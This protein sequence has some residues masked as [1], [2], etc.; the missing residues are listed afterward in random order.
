MKP[1]LLFTD[2][3][4][5]L[6]WR[7]SRDMA[8]L[9]DDL[10]LVKLFDAMAQGDKFLYD[11]SM[12]AVLQGLV[13]PE[14][15][16]YRQDV[17]RDC[18][19]N[20]ETVREMYATAVTALESQR[21]VWPFMREHPHSIVRQ[22]AHALRLYATALKSLRRLA[23]QHSADFCSAGMST[24]FRMLKTELDDAYLDELDEQLTRLEFKG[25]VLMSAELGK[26]NKGIRYVLR[27]PLARRRDLKQLIGLSPRASYSFEIG[28][29][30]DAGAR[31]LSELQDRAM[32]TVGNALAQSAD[33][34]RSFFTT[35]QAELGFYVCC[36][37]LHD[38]L[39]EKGEPV[40]FPVPRERELF[41]LSFSGLYDV[42]LALGSDVPVVGND[43]NAD[44]KRLVMITGA[45]S[46]GKSTFL[47]SVGLA[48]L[49]MQSGMFV[50]AEAFAGSVC[51][52][53][54]THFIREEDSTMTSGRLAEELSRMDAIANALTPHCM[55][56][57]N[58]SFAATNER[59]GSEIARQVITALIESDIRVV[60]VTHLFDLAD[61]LYSQGSEKMLFLRA[62]RE[63]DAKQRF[64][65]EEGRP[66]ST[67]FGEDVLN[68][69]GGLP[70]T[71]RTPSA[72]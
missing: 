2:R 70:P 25:G 39:A 35:L 28:Q 42:C 55:V 43:A 22:S 5:D 26:G 23:D 21:Q 47:R 44:G 15:I 66:L 65:L 33:H 27:K 37:N 4:Y 8:D 41:S 24:F 67:S 40:C 46:G 10:N 11:V 7:P 34:M 18:L 16:V 1:H 32:N 30:D 54:F 45:N 61:G 38:L 29:R 6:S 51:T 62:E 71:R 69:I 49:M 64:K 13:D 9:L 63:T 50:G 48:Q 60:Y 3:D 68:R 12:G 53:V 56:L 31:V 19:N 59:E 17:L 20:P 36:L 72:R 14:Q 52:G 57:F 58:E